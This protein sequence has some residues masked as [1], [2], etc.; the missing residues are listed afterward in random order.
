MPGVDARR[1]ALSGAM[2]AC[3]AWPTLVRAASPAASSG[4]SWSG[5]PPL[6]DAQLVDHLGRAVWLR[7]VLREQTGVVISFFYTGCSTVCPPQTALLRD[8]RQQLDSRTDT[9]RVLLVSISVD[10]LGDG[11]DQVRDHLRRFQIDAGPDKGWLWL[12]GQPAEVS[13]V[14]RGFGVKP[15]A[16][17]D[18]PNLLWMADIRRERWTRTAALQEPRQVA[19]RLQELLS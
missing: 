16:A 17:A 19:Q 6:P 11:P 7:R 3:G 15:S 10:P 2:L 8:L 1:R 12:T 13:G 5:A 14:L 9:R 4:A 18:H